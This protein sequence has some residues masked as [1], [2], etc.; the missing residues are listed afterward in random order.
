VTGNPVIAPGGSPTQLAELPAR[1]GVVVRTGQIIFRWRDLLFPAVALFIGFGTRPV[2]TGASMSVDHAV[3]AAG[4]GVSL[5]GQFW[6]VLVIGLVYITRGGQNRQ[7]W[8]NA[9]VEQ[10]VF[11]HCRNPLYIGNLLIVT[12]LAIVH[13]GWAMYL[14]TVPFFG[15]AYSAVVRAE[16][17]YLRER[18]GDVY[19]NY[20]ERVPRWRPLVR[21]L[22]ATWGTGRIDWLKVLRKE[23]GTPFGWL[24]GCVL[25]LVWE[26]YSPSATPL[27]RAELGLLA[28]VW[29]ALAV[30]YVVAR[31]LKL[32]DLLGNE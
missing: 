31:V 6:R 10:G 26:H 12:G 21:G 27:D 19:A 22:P 18:F 30:A 23:Y 11:A 25:L 32:R 4:L 29:C 3:D 20:C 28:G 5:G 9:L 13:G 14:I 15:L 16:E 24:S 7:I 17:W 2:I 8:A 1:P